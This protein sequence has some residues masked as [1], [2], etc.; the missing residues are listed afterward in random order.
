MRL[1][2]VED[3]L[4]IAAFLVKGLIASGYSVDHAETGFDALRR[5]DGDP[6]YDLVLLDLGLP[7]LDGLEVLRTLREGGSTL[8][9]IVLTARSADRDEGL[10]LGADDFL[11]K[12]LPFRALLERLQA[13]AA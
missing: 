4:R 2:V 12:P 3:E 7:D 13:C 8:P 1:L 11:I 10:R 9:V 6:G 5:L